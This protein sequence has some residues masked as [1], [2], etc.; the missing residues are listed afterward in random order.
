MATYSSIFPMEREACQA[1]VHEV[2][3]SD[4]IE[5]LTHINHLNKFIVNHSN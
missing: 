4:M 5:Q 3:E 1:T 2:A